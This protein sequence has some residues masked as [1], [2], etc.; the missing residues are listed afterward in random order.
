M[1]KKGF[2]TEEEKD[3]FIDEEEQKQKSDEYI[4]YLIKNDKVDMD[5]ATDLQKEIMEEL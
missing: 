4:S 2:E 3:K 5:K 1:K